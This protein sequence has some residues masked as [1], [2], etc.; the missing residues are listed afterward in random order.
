MAQLSG[1]GLP[2]IAALSDTA[3]FIPAPPGRVLLR[4]TRRLAAQDPIS[5][6]M[7]KPSAAEA[8]LPAFS[9]CS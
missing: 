5:P 1:R 8:T 4:M 2:L 6:A 9:I 3:E 7:Q